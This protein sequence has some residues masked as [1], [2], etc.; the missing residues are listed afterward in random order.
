MG[1]SF[2]SKDIPP[3]FNF[4]NALQNAE[5]GTEKHARACF[6][7]EQ[8]VFR[9]HHFTTF[10]QMKPPKTMSAS[11]AKPTLIFARSVKAATR[12]RR[13]AMLT[14]RSRKRFAL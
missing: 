7:G 13:S 10:Q 12:Y 6:I 14:G 1:F 5:R 9:L 8:W 4:E 3:Q 11:C 2:V